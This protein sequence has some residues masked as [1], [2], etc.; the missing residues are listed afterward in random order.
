MKITSK[1]KYYA[2]IICII[3]GCAQTNES[4]IKS[5]MSNCA[6]K[7]IPAYSYEVVVF[8][9]TRSFGIIDFVLDEKQIKNKIS[10]ILERSDIFSFPATKT[11]PTIRH[12]KSGLKNGISD[13]HFTIDIGWDEIT[14]MDE[15]MDEAIRP[16][17]LEGSLGLLP[18]TI[19]DK[20]IM[21]IAVGPRG[22]Q[23]KTFHYEKYVT[24]LFW[25]PIEFTK[26]VMAKS[27]GNSLV[28]GSEKFI[29]KI[30]K[31]MSKFIKDISKEWCSKQHSA[32]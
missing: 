19:S 10:D 25:G 13:Y 24:Y 21:N 31:M 22:A 20:I 2:I 6:E 5:E 28:I 32:D 23:T 12:E 3:A 30:E 11:Y 9:S 15:F 7:M 14:L 4:V 18:V 17:I 26:M 16:G 8:K 1:Y 27:D 29:P